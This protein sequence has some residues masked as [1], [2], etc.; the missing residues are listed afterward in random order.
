M[1]PG[2]FAKRGIDLTIR[3]GW[4]D[5]PF[6]EMLTLCTRQGICGL[7]FAAECGRNSAFQNMA[8]RWPQARFVEDSAYASDWV[9]A[10]L[11]QQG[12]TRLMLSGTPFQIKVWEALMTIPEGRVATYGEI[13]RSIGNPNAFRAAGSAIGRNPISW[14]IPCHRVIRKSGSLGGYE[15]GLPIKKTLLAWESAKRVAN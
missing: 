3:Y 6:G 14:L 1:T 9:N 12:E 5:S 2:E 11:N 7:A 4:F 10:V 8:S 13:A 15:W